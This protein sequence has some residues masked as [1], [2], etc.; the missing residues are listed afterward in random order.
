MAILLPNSAFIHVQKTGGTWVREVLRR[1]DL[2]VEELR[3]INKKTSTEF[4]KNSVH[5]VPTWDA[6]F[7]ERRLIFCFV[8]HPL[9]WYQSYWAFKDGQEKWNRRKPFDRKCRSASFTQFVEGVIKNYSSEGYLTGLYREYTEPCNFVGKFENLTEELVRALRTANEDFQEE[10]IRAT[11]P[12]NVAYGRP[13]ETESCVYPEEL[14]KRIMDI[15]R[16]AVMKYD[17]DYYPDGVLL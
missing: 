9:T 2:L 8:R 6:R 17:Y 10:L 15:E 5:C 13:E 3:S 16:S 12:M 11:A 1:T 4:I 7:R 14:A